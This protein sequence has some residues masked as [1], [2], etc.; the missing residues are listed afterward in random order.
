MRR[1]ILTTTLALGIVFIISAIVGYHEAQYNPQLGEGLKK[2]FEGFRGFMENPVL[3]M[4]IIFANNAGKSL[5]AML[6]GFF[7]GIFPVLFVILNGY[8]VGVVVSVKSPE[9]GIYKV[10]AAILPHGI[11]E[12]PAIIISCAYGVWLGYRF[13]RA[14]F[15]GEEFKKYV[16][17]A[18]KVYLRFIVPVLFIAA[19]VEAFITPL[20]VSVL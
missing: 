2:F 9:W 3:L 8:I 18:I 20:V 1:V 7:F 4:L 11:L 16:V 12:I 19:V 14:L 17:Y 10:I 6:A 15:N 5:V 13:Y